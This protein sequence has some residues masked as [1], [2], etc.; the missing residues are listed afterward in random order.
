MCVSCGCGQPQDHHDDP[1]HITLQDLDQAAQA[2]EI[3]REQ[4]VQH[5]MQAVGEESSF[6]KTSGLHPG[7]YIPPLGQDSGSAYPEGFDEYA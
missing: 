4:V 2:A 3:T 6:F 7:D 5:I 1:R